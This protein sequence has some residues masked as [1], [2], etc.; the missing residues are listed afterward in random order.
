MARL[1]WSNSFSNSSNGRGGKWCSY[2]R[3]TLIVCSINI[4]VAL[5]VL[6]SLYTSLYMYPYND[7]VNG[8]TLASLSIFSQFLL[9]LWMT[10]LLGFEAYFS[11]FTSL[12]ETG[13]W[14]FLD[15]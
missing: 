4:V 8:E 2:K 12:M 10:H 13:F 1:E 3:T 7:S 15:F 11:D 9:C 6:H 5:Y 14:V